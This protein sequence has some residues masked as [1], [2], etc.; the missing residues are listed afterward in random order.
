MIA[1]MTTQCFLL[2]AKNARR[3]V[4]CGLEKTKFLKPLKSGTLATNR[5]VIAFLLAT[6][7]VGEVTV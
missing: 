4:G 7:K 6:N 3:E 1:W 5:R 2:V